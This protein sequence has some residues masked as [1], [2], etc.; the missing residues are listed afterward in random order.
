MTVSRYLL[1]CGALGL[2][3]VVLSVV[4]A[5]P[6]RRG[7]QRHAHDC[8]ACRAALADVDAL[9]HERACPVCREAQPASRCPPRP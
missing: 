1:A 2:L 6:R 8:P 9:P 7:R 5:R 3:L 4:L